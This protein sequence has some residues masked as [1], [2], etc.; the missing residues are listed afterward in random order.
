MPDSSAPAP[1]PP[2]PDRVDPE[3]LSRLDAAQLDA[4][5]ARL[6]GV[7]RATRSAM[8]PY[9]RQLREVR[10][11]LEEIGTERRRRE[12]LERHSRRMSVREQAAS[13]EMPGLDEALGGDPPPLLDTTPL[14]QVRAHLRSG[15]EVAFGY[16]SRPGVVSFTDGRQ[17][18]SATTWGEARQLYADGWEP[19]SPG[20][21][22]V[23]GVRVHLTGT[24]VE[25]VVEMSDVVVATG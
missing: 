4:E 16:P 15:G 12:R 13:G 24:R 1:P 20:N 19:G 7:E 17:M 6:A 3:S 8:S 9:E 23:R 18:R 2:L 5:A 25:R 21:P 14:S 10:T 11:R 22:G